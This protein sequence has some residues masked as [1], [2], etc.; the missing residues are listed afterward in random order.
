MEK[1]ET[2]FYAITLFS[3]IAFVYIAFGAVSKIPDITDERFMSL[4][5]NVVI[6]LED[7]FKIGDDIYGDIILTEKDTDVYGIILLTKD[8]EPIITKTFNLND[9]S[10]SKIDS[11]KFLI[12]IEDL[13]NYSFGEKGSYEL[14]FSVLDLDVNIKKDFIVE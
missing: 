9:I 3:L 4:T 1:G 10:K 2:M 14:F 7:N 8:S 12:K 11:K 13:I 5:G 6:D